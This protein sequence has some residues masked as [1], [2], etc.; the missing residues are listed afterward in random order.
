MR[1]LFQT[2]VIVIMVLVVGSLVRTS[3][4]PSAEPLSLFYTT[5][6]ANDSLEAGAAVRMMGEPIGV[7]YSVEPGSAGHQT[8]AIAGLAES[9]FPWE[10]VARFE[11][12]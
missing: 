4:K 7:V 12:T 9:E 8:V 2:F 6:P 10:D 3:V 11:I 1:V 5:T